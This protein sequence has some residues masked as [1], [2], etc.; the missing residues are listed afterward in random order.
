MKSP[1]SSDSEAED[2][3]NLMTWAIVR[4]GQF[5]DGTDTSS[6]IIM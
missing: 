2:M 3:V 4:S 6:E 5:M 1:A